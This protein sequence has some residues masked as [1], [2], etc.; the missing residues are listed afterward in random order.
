MA[1]KTKNAN[2]E[3]N[4]V[5]T[6]SMLSQ[7]GGDM[8][9]KGE[10]P[11][12]KLNVLFQSSTEYALPCR[13]FL[14]LEKVIKSSNKKQKQCKT[15]QNPAHLPMPQQA[16]TASEHDDTESNGGVDKALNDGMDKD[17]SHRR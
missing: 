2:T 7:K 6:F 14:F 5:G 1:R 3:E 4:L 13:V 11:K 12:L 9:F 8:R 15:Q 17:L 10:K 16:P